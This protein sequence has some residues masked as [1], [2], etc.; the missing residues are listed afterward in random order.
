[1]LA[2]SWSLNACGFKETLFPKVFNKDAWR[3]SPASLEKKLLMTRQ[4]GGGARHSE[5]GPGPG[6]FG[7]DPSISSAFILNFS[8]C[9][10]R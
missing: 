1:M 4:E 7:S 3:P 2:P 8:G 10:C 6:T 9:L 5:A